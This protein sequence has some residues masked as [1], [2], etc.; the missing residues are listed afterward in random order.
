[1]SVNVLIYLNLSHSVSVP[2][3]G[4]P[5]CQYYPSPGYRYWGQGGM[6]DGNWNQIIGWAESLRPFL[7]LI[8]TKQCGAHLVGSCANMGGEGLGALR[9]EEYQSLCKE[10]GESWDRDGMAGAMWCSGKEFSRTQESW[11]LCY[12]N[13]WESPYPLG[14]SVYIWA[15]FSGFLYL[16]A[17]VPGVKHYIV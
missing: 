17:N 3:R 1:M 2:E 7:S 11:V 5:M 9:E 16:E 8:Q 14:R 10:V 4:S 15:G 12:V 6:C 13:P